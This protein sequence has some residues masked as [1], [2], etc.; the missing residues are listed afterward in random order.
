MVEKVECIVIGAGVIGL[1]V[2]RQLTRAGREVVVVEAAARIGTEMSSHNSEVIH[3]G[4]YYPRD[5]LKARSCVAGRKALYAYCAEHGVAH[6]KLG[7]LIVATGEEE[8]ER[9]QGLRAGAAMNGVTDLVSLDAAAAREM[10][11]ALRCLAALH[12]PSTGI[13]DGHALMLS[14]Q[15][16]AED[17]GAAI[18][19]NSP[20]LGGSVEGDGITLRIGGGEPMT[21]KAR[22][23]VNATGLKAQEVAKSLSGLPRSSIPT[24]YLAKGNYFTLRGRSPFSKLIYPLPDCAGLGI[25]LTLDMGGQARF[26]P[27]V[28]WVGEAD[29][30]VDRRRGDAFYGAIRRYFPD[31]ADGALQPGYAGVRPKLHGPGGAAQ[32][33]VVQG[34]RDHGVPGL[35]NFYGIESPGLTA[36]FPLAEHAVR[37][38]GG[39]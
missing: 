7:K 34:S 16:A 2:A 13:I 27:D 1:A 9:L 31:L 21:L 18:A 11:P 15:G 39:R 17:L 37:L 26:G 3:A 25:H 4:I 14:L 10:E 33:F 38:L 32:D 24:L 30:D 8:V 6:R 22:T 36:I 35:V 29:H 19:F 5:S 20:V 28:E 23:V 12:S